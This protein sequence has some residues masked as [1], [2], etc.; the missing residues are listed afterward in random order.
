MADIVPFFSKS[1]ALLKSIREIIADS[2]RVSFASALQKGIAGD[3]AMSQIWKC[4]EEGSV[5]YG[6]VFNDHG[7]AMCELHCISAGQAIYL[8]I[9]VEG[10]TPHERRIHVL[11]VSEG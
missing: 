11:Q 5:S 3:V 9:A 7:H 8:S 4:L 10:D 2:S 1:E 6:P